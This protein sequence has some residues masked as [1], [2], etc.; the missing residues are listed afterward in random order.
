MHYLEL[1]LALIIYQPTDVTIAIEVA[2]KGPKLLIV[3]DSYLKL[4]ID[5]RS[6]SPLENAA[7]GVMNADA[8]GETTVAIEELLVKAQTLAQENKWKIRHE[9]IVASSSITAQTNYKTLLSQIKS[10]TGLKVLTVTAQEEA[11]LVFQ[12]TVPTAKRTDSLIV[13]VGSGNSRLA[14]VDE[15]GKFKEI[16]I[17]L[18]TVTATKLKQ[19]FNNDDFL[20]QITDLVKLQVPKKEIVYVTGG[21]AWALQ[22]IVNAPNQLYTP[23]HLSRVMKLDHTAEHNKLT[24]IQHQITKVFTPANLIAGSNLLVGILKNFPIDQEIIFVNNPES[25]ILQFIKETEGKNK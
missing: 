8:M 11:R 18:G 22:T 16:T 15:S 23:F 10:S 21:I 24:K 14:Y 6:V 13:D 20:N 3:S 2:G 17:P 7:N 9:I 25:W 12:A 1:L 4:F 5:R 19:D